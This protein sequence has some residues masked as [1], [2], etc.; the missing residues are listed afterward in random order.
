[1]TVMCGG[2]AQAHRQI[3]PGNHL[4]SQPSVWLRDYGESLGS[5][6][7]S[8]KRKMWR[9]SEF[10]QMQLL[11]RG[12]KFLCWSQIPPYWHRVKSGIN[13]EISNPWYGDANHYCFRV[14]ITIF[15]VG[16]LA[17]HVI[18]YCLVKSFVVDIS[19]IT[20]ECSSL[21]FWLSG[22]GI[23]D[24][25]VVV[26]VCFPLGITHCCRNFLCSR[27]LLHQIGVVESKGNWVNFS[28]RVYCS[29]WNEHGYVQ[30][31]YVIWFWR[32]LIGL[33]LSQSSSVIWKFLHSYHSS[34]FW[35][36]VKSR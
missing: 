16:I 21:L 30:C 20:L 2:V 29:Q 14:M 34:L 35:H 36:N 7:L 31:Q 4:H 13:T 17:F 5:M 25:E 3:G 22:V 26:G 11:C 27:H 32:Y 1:M 9:V 19:I 18:R 23:S 28:T 10:C 15:L 12:W 6:P 24:S 8:Q 33:D